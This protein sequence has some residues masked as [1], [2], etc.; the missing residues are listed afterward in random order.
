MTT[1]IVLLIISIVGTALWTLSIDQ[2]LPAPFDMRT[3][4]GR[5]WRR[6][7]PKASK[8]EI[9]QFLLTFTE[10][11][12]FDD[13]D[14]LKFN[15]NDQ[16]LDIYRALYPHKWQPDGLEFEILSDILKSKYKVKLSEIWCEDMTLGQL[17]QQVW[18]H[19]IHCSRA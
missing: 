18:Q 17:F 4:Q 5:D 8:F 12:A 14:K 7:F 2:I 10:A 15:P 9:R 6:S 16:L 11:F 3:R 13:Q 19:G 1:I